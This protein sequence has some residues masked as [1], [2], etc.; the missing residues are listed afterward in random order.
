[1]KPLR[2]I[3][4]SKSNLGIFCLWASI[5]VIEKLVGK[6]FAEM[7]Q[8]LKRETERG[9]GEYKVKMQRKSSQRQRRMLATF[10]EFLP[11]I[12]ASKWNENRTNVKFRTHTHTHT[13]HTC[14]LLVVFECAAQLHKFVLVATA[15]GNGNPKMLHKT[16]RP[17]S[18]SCVCVAHSLGAACACCASLL[19]A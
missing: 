15:A 4:K 14:T 8:K 10:K 9:R 19:L 6:V 3:P 1:M 5:N 18:S 7:C 2:R 16:W 17:T 11:S 12:F 13:T